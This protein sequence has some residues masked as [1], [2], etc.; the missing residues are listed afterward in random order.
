MS[1]RFARLQL[2]FHRRVMDQRLSAPDSKNGNAAVSAN[3]DIDHVDGKYALASRHSA[4]AN[5]VLLEL[6]IHLF[7]GQSALYTYLMY[8]MYLCQVRKL[9]RRPP[10]KAPYIPNFFFPT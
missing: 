4:T 8:L 2:L 1:T 5:E 6:F 3:V 9:G 10:T 7:S